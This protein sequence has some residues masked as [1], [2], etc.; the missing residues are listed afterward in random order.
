MVNTRLCY[1]PSLL[2]F[3]EVRESIVKQNLSSNTDENDGAWDVLLC[4]II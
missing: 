4:N 1:K 3:V 2:A